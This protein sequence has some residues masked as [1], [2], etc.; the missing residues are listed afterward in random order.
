MVSSSSSSGIELLSLMMKLL[1]PHPQMLTEVPW[2]PQPLVPLWPL[3]HGIWLSFRALPPHSA[4]YPLSVSPSSSTD[5]IPVP[6]HLFLVA[7]TKAHSSALCSWR[8]Y[9]FTFLDFNFPLS[10][11]LP[12]L[13]ATWCPSWTSILN[14]QQPK[15]RIHVDALF[16][17]QMK[18]AELGN[19]YLLFKMV[20]FPPPFFYSLNN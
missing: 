16:P 15:G 9:L 1:W 7:Q 13:P 3:S 20:L 2:Q 6:C 18:H 17:P 10:A 19:N 14:R 4:V 11:W 5:L 12:I 8:I